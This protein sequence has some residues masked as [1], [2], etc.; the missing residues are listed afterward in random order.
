VNLKVFRNAYYNKRA[1]LSIDRVLFRNVSYAGDG[2]SSSR[3]RGY[4]SP[5]RVTN[6]TIENMTRN[7]QTVLEPAAGNIVVGPHTANISFRKQPPTKS[8]GG[9]DR[10]IRY[11]G[12][13]LRRADAASRGG[14][15]HTAQLSGSRLSYAF[16]GRQAR[17]LGVTGPAAGKVD[18]YVDGVYAVSVDTYSNA[19]RAEQIWYD[20][21]VLTAGRHVL[22]LRYR[23]ARNILAT[24]AEIAFDY[25][26]IVS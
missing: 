6:V 4:T 9:L 17:V 21:G 25:L 2:D 3:I 24:G 15:V 8:V 26:E 1:G 16:T 12:P 13:W 5:R 23:G 22:E 7:G 11:S 19:R 18:V 10:A 20:T 14:D